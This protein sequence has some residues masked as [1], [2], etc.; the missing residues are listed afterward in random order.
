[1]GT[2]ATLHIE[3]L[4]TL[5]SLKISLFKGLEVKRNAYMTYPL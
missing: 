3:L 2:I 4:G 5:R 1:M